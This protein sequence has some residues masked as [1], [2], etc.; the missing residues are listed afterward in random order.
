MP[1][2]GPITLLVGATAT[3]TLLYFDQHGLP[4]PADFIPPVTT[5]TVDTPSVVSSAPSGD[6]LSDLL[7]ALAEG[8]CTVSAIVVT[9]EGA[10]LQDSSGITVTALPPPPA[11]LSS[12]KLSFTLN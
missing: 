9:A 3:A 2:P 12:V 4:M 1:T 10:T 6:L 7:T 5:F 8:T 11:T